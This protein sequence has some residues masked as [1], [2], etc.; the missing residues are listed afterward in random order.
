MAGRPLTSVQGKD[1]TY[2]D[3]VTTQ[4]YDLAGRLTTTADCTT[5]TTGA[6]ATTLRTATATY[7]GA[8][9][10]LT[11]TSREGRTSQYG[12][13]NA[14]QLT[15]ITQR[16]N[17]AD[18]TTAVT[19]ELGY[20]LT[21]QRTRMVDGNA[22]ATT[23]TYTPWGQTASVIEPATT[24]HPNPSDRTWT[25]TYD[26]AGQPV[27]YRLPGNVSRILTYDKLGNLTQETGTG[28]EATTATR[29]LGYDL[30]GRITSVGG[31]N[32]A[33]NY[34][35][36]DRDQLSSVTGAA[37]DATYT[38][39][40][41]GNL[42]NRTDAAGTATFT[43]NT[44]GALATTA[45]PLTGVTATNVYKN[46]GQ[47]GQTT[48]GSGGPTRAYTYDSL[49]RLAT[50]TY[51]KPNGTTTASTTYTYDKDDLLLT[52]TTTG[53]TGAGTNTYGYDGLA[54]LTTWKSP[55]NQQTTYGYDNASNR[56][57][58][59]NPTGTRTTTYDA[60]NRTTTANGADQP[61]EAW[62]WTPRGTLSTHTAGTTVDTNTFD[63]FERL[64]QA[65]S[66]GYTINYTYDALDRLAQRN[67]LPFLYNDQTNQP[68]RT[69]DA[70]TQDTVILRS[71]DGQPLSDKAGTA[72]ARNLITDRIHNDLTAATNPSTGDLTAS[73]TY[74]P[75][76]QP[77]AATGTL[78]LGYQGGWTDPDTT[79]TNAHARWY[80]PASGAFTG[81]DTWT[82]WPDPTAQA[83]RYSYGNSNPISYTDPSGHLVV[84]PAAA[85]VLAAG[86]AAAGPTAGLTLLAAGV[87]VTGFM[88]YSH[89]NKPQPKANPAPAPA[90]A[91]APSNWPTSTINLPTQ[92]Y[93]ERNPHS[94][95][96]AF[97]Y[98]PGRPPGAQPDGGGAPGVSGPCSRN[99]DTPPPIPPCVLK[100]LAAG[101]AGG[102][103]CRTPWLLDV[104]ARPD[105]TDSVRRAT[106]SLV[107]GSGQIGNNPNN[108]QAPRVQS[109]GSG[110][111]APTAIRESGLVP[112][113]G[114]LQDACFT[115]G[116]L[117][118]DGSRSSGIWQAGCSE[119][120]PLAPQPISD[121]LFERM[122]Y[123]Y[124]LY[125]TGQDYEERFKLGGKIIGVD[126]GPTLTNGYLVEA[127]FTG[128]TEKQWED[129]PHNPANG[130]FN[131]DKR[132]QQVQRLLDLNSALG[133]R[134]VRFVASNQLGTLFFR[135]F[136]QEWFPD[137]MRDGTLGVYNVPIGDGMTRPA[138]KNRR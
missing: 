29:Q 116:W 52:K 63:A 90:K 131:V 1:T 33:T 122:S 130:M 71:P 38:Y 82:L 77:T 69:P 68:I 15:A 35:W 67:T 89:Y 31:P 91:P 55:T 51:K 32:G 48:Y 8:S 10:P 102:Q 78:P 9:Q 138:R 57:T 107:T 64:T 121:K 93:C 135:S 39:D 75:Y 108:V 40:G 60:R 97:V 76:G 62:T 118:A 49:G 80:N 113:Q 7:N 66:T 83:N 126:G 47:L 56:T 101:L 109:D 134:G 27:T 73:R 127:K 46:N 72:A 98:A 21:G 65:T 96:C 45:D 133:A 114:E 13:D 105:K 2:V 36:N 25:T 11:V 58:V 94:P 115:G 137:Q 104:G 19:V 44:A 37:G 100:S 53:V 95:S 23:Y 129:S 50:D 61:A 74:Q 6:C 81:R 17:P 84:A 85:G 5:T 18:A 3:P 119:A 117:Q 125:V 41:E 110:E 34:T 12:Y 24:A 87:I 86:G 99:C 106:E 42:S 28:A 30:N 132:V 4:T 123:H 112:E 136:L 16:V 26:A 124:Q 128:G 103:L 59:T 43:Y 20:D 70:P 79:Q 22:N 14:G 54:R 111:S 120:M 88:I 92:N